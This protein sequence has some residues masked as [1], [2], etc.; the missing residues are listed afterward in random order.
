MFSFYCVIVCLEIITFRNNNKSK[1]VSGDSIKK[2]KKAPME[3]EK[4][5]WKQR[6]LH[7]TII[8][9]ACLC[10]RSGRGSKTEK[11]ILK[12]LA[13]PDFYI[14][15]VQELHSVILFFFL[16]FFNV[17]RAKSF[18]VTKCFQYIYLFNNL[19]TMCQY[20]SFSTL[21]KLFLFY[22]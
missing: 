12:N 7:Y 19:K 22:A 9:G 21:R 10:R 5:R 15:C 3:K 11:K 16:S 8:V 1:N 6:L 20:F 18:K 2:L 17:Q 4:E 14:I 13:L